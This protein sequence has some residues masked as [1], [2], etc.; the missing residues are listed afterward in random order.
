MDNSHRCKYCESLIHDHI[1]TMFDI[2]DYTYDFLR[3][4]VIYKHAHDISKFIYAAYM[5][6]DKVY[7]IRQLMKDIY[8][9]IVSTYHLTQDVNNI[10]DRSNDIITHAT[11]WN[12]I[13]NHYPFIMKEIEHYTI[14]LL[15]DGF[16]IS[17]VK[18]PFNFVYDW[19]IQHLYTL[20]TQLGE[21]HYCHVNGYTST[22]KNK[23]TTTV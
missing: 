20:F 23:L 14:L 3:K 15:E 10:Y 1:T 17:E 19:F 5:S 16:V 12:K 11:F 21:I 13:K 9:Q 2:H 6:A 22:H 4:K 7:S 8:D 18:T